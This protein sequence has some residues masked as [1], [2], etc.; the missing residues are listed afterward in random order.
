M[1]IK[2]CNC[3]PGCDWQITWNQVLIYFKPKFNT[4]KFNNPKVII[5]DMNQNYAYFLQKRILLIKA[6]IFD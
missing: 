6:E 5:N 2:K 1:Q 4:A 3:K